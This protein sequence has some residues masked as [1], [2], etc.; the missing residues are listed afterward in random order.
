MHENLRKHFDM[1]FWGRMVQHI[2][3]GEGDKAFSLWQAATEKAYQQGC[4]DEGMNRENPSRGEEE[5]RCELCTA[6]VCY[7]RYPQKRYVRWCEGGG[8]TGISKKYPGET[9]NYCKR[10]L[11]N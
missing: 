3:E 4:Y 11:P 10:H 5:R 7:R 2:Q 1:D 9:A 6:V 8:Q